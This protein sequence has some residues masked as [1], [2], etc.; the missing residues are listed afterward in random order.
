[1]CVLQVYWSVSAD[2]VCITGILV[3][4]YRRCVYYR[5]TGL[6]LQTM[7]VLHVTS[8]LATAVQSLQTMCVMHVTNVLPPAVQ[9]VHTLMCVA[10]NQCATYCCP[11]STDGVCIACN[12]CATYCCPVCP[13]VDVC[14]MYPPCL[15]SCCLSSGL[16]AT[17]TCWSVS[18]R[19]L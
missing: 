2:D 5:Y 10:C 4:L 1:M 7:R 12:Q 6:S 15:V 13:Y 19:P 18:H 8:V 9:S 17:A 3:C 14:C 11:I 16:C